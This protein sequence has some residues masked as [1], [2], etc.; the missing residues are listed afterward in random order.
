MRKRPTRWNEQLDEYLFIKFTAG[1][2]IRSIAAAIGC[3]HD[4]VRHRYA[5]LCKWRGFQRVDRRKLAA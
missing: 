5:K 3:S 1:D 2:P 4:A